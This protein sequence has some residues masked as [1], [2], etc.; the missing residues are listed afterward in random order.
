MELS[1]SLAEE[2]NAGFIDCCWRLLNWD[3]D[4]PKMLFEADV[5]VWGAG[6]DR[7]LLSDGKSASLLNETMSGNPIR[8]G[9]FGCGRWGWNWNVGGIVPG[10]VFRWLLS[11]EPTGIALVLN[12]F[13]AFCPLAEAAFNNDGFVGNW[14]RMFCP[15]LFTTEFEPI[16]C[17]WDCGPETL[18]ASNVPLLKSTK[19]LGTMKMDK[20]HRTCSHSS[21]L[22]NLNSM[23]FSAV[24]Q[25]WILV[26][27]LWAAQRTT[28]LIHNL[29]DQLIYVQIGFYCGNNKN[30]SDVFFFS[31][32][33]SCVWWIAENFLNVLSRFNNTPN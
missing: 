19:W 29:I 31:S 27:C 16:G 9:L 5:L 14:P 18:D 17:C 33:V 15:G 8:W 30:K 26:S 12:I 24:K 3:W 2:Y 25:R 10:G 22:K 1:A 7:V 4:A 21:V 23:I 11:I 13:A 6:E 20:P 32:I 28:T